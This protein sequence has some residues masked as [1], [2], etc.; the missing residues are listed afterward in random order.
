M[1]VNGR[2]GR[3]YREAIAARYKASPRFREMMY[4]QSL[5][6]SIPALILAA[7]LTVIAV[8]PWVPENWSYGVCWTAPFIWCFIWGCFTIRI[9]KAKMVQERLE[10]E[11]G[12][13]PGKEIVS[14]VM[15]P[16]TSPVT[17]PV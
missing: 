14:P 10:W 16:V 6:W 5:F 8:I 9:C 15:S 7:I 11:A 13:V 3:P 17:S 4:Q 12:E 1:A 2:C